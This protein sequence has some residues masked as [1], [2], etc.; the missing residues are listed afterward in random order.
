MK[1]LRPWLKDHAH[2]IDDRFRDKVLMP[3]L[4]D[5]H[6]HPSLPAVLTHFP[7]LAPDDWDLPTGSF[8]GAKTPEAYVARL[9]E[10]ASQHKDKDIPFI[11]WG[12]HP[13]W[14]GEQYG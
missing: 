8:P 2:E 5:A 13:L 4:I 11:C 14:H 6:V 9:K 3:G 1:S 10:L 12:Y 7:F